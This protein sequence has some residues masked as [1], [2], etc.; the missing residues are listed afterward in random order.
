MS[1]ATEN[2]A[3]LI[4]EPAEDYHRRSEHSKG[5][6]YDFHERPRIFEGR[7]I[8]KTIPLKETTAG[9]GIGTLVHAALLEPHKLHELYAVVPEELLASNGALSTKAAKDFV[10][11][12]R[13]RG[14]IPLK[15]D[16]FQVVAAMAQSVNAACGSWLGKA[17][18]IEQTITWT[19]PATGLA[20]RCKPDWIRPTKNG[21][22]IAFD[23]KTTADISA[24]GFRGSVENFGYWLQDAHYSEGIEAATGKPVDAFYFV[25]VESEAPYACRV[26]QLDS[27][28]RAAAKEAREDLLAN[29]AECYRTGEFRDSFEGVVTPISVRPFAYQSGENQ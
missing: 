5:M 24:H 2:T 28:S 27:E 14:Q 25:A 1:I 26:F 21:T 23:L 22:S 6:L 4:A 8:T 12:A 9:M 16:Q 3:R 13:G 11:T 19:H 15:A 18:L 17:A 29:L 20:C 10:A 7:Y